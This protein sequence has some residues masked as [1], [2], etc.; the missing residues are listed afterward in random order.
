MRMSLAVC[1]VGLLACRGPE[2]PDGP[3]GPKGEP[4]EQ[5]VPGADGEKG[6]P[7]DPGPAGADGLPRSKADLYEVSGNAIVANGANG[8][9]MAS[10]A[11]AN[12]VLLHGWCLGAS[13]SGLDVTAFK[14]YNSVD[15]AQV[16]SYACWYT[17]T[18]GSSAAAYAYAVC[19]DVP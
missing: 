15:D 19:I 18:S 14:V 7:G 12:D 2:G 5:G 3:E 17:N 10:C 8:Q 4:G 13:P 1:L 9:A 16:S 6:E 11:D